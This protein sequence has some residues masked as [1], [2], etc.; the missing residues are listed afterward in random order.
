MGKG[1]ELRGVV[2]TPRLNAQ[3]ARA[4]YLVKQAASASRAKPA[5]HLLAAGR[6]ANPFLELAA[7]QLQL[8]VLN[9]SRHAK[10]AARLALAIGA[11]AYK[12][13]GGFA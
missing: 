7:L 1:L 9:P 11:M 5:S 4:Q 8:C 10:R 13:G 12:S 2:E 3:M 6:V